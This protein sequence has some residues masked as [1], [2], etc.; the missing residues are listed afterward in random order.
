MRE[1]VKRWYVV[2]VFL[3]VLSWLCTVKVS[4]ASID[5]SGTCGDN[6]T[7]TLDSDGVLAVSGEGKMD[8]YTYYTAQDQTD[9]PWDWRRTVIKKVIIE[10]GVT[11]VGKSAFW[12]CT[13]LTEV[14]IGDTVETIEPNAFHTC[15]ALATITMGDNVE[16]VGEN[17]F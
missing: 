1:T 4:A 14:V 16:T 10:D 9:S 8:S 3:A 6:L 7:W 17:A 5:A 11:S 12:G 15:T 2:V 13:N